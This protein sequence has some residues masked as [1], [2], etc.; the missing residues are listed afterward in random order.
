MPHPYRSFNKR[1]LYHI[2]IITVGSLETLCVSPTDPRGRW[3]PGALPRGGGGSQEDTEDLIEDIPQTKP[4]SASNSPRVQREITQTNEIETR[5]QSSAL[6]LTLLL[7]ESP[8]L[9]FGFD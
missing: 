5:K 3:L 6:I 2:S 9:H 4:A 1:P 7:S 8:L